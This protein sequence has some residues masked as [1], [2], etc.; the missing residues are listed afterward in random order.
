M[1]TRPYDIIYADPPWPQKKVVR[2][3]RPNQKPEL[4]YHTEPVERCIELCVPFFNKAAPKHNVFM[5]AIDKF[6]PDTERLMADLGYKVHARL[7]WDKTNGI[8][9]ARTVRFSHEYLLWFFKRGGLL[10]PRPEAI[11]KY[12]TVMREKSTVHSRKPQCAYE[13]L[14]DM[15]PDAHK[16]ELFCRTPRPGWDAWGDEVP[17]EIAV[18]IQE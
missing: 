7:I 15:F 11:G 5:W 4:D 1:D 13:M 2:K 3:V 10:Y 17:P 18:N 8:P 9:A 6:I 16:I 12:T 14:E